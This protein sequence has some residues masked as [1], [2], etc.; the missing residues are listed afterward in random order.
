LTKKNKLGIVAR[1]CDPKYGSK[2]KLNSQSR[3]I[4]AIKQDS[5]SKITKAKRDRDV[6][7]VIEDLP[8]KGKVLSSNTSTTKN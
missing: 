2:H 5:I 6:V 4:W 1:T 7:Q 3:P 8:Y